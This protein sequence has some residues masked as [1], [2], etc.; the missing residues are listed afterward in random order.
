MTDKTIAATDLTISEKH[1]MYIGSFWIFIIAEAMMF[2]TIFSTRF[3]LAG[4][5]KSAEVSQ[6]IGILSSVLM[7]VSLWSMQRTYASS[8][9]EKRS[10][11]SNQLTL[12]G[13][14]GLIVL[15]INGYEWMTTSMDWGSRFGEVF[16][17]TTLFHE[18]HLLG[19]VIALF[20]MAIHAKKRTFTSNNYWPV[21]AMS[22]YW[23]FVTV[24]WLCEYILF[25]LI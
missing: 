4:T 22:I 5:S 23:V 7:L 11:L 20:A 19:G 9:K 6:V 21:R 13:V 17:I 24:V 25:Y 16:Y 3:L 1:Q 15:L 8:K 14:I 2:V 18:V 10:N 12:T